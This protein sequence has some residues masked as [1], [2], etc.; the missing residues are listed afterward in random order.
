MP[1]YFRIS[2]TVL[3]KFRRYHA[4]QSSFDTEKALLDALAGVFIGTDKTAI[5]SAYHS[6]IEKAHF[7]PREWNGTEYAIFRHKG[8]TDGSHPDVGCIGLPMAS[9]QPV[10]EYSD[11][12]YRMF[13]EVP[14]S[15][16]YHTRIPGTGEIGFFVSG[17]ADGIEGITI[18]DAKFKFREA[19]DISEYM[20][21]MQWKITLDITEAPLFCFDLF[22]VQNYQGWPSPVNLAPDPSKSLH[23]CIMLNPDVQVIQ[24]PEIRCT[25]TQNLRGEIDELLFYFADWLH[26]RNLFHLLKPC[27]SDG[28][29]IR[30]QIP[31]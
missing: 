19:G 6:Q 30:P 9:L 15:K 7:T 4:N 11:A 13:R 8:I 23:P 26:F 12:H 29:V 10:A 25:P 2:I 31:G 24:Q 14:I 16:L 21:S 28:F 17:R 18:R 5:G 20:E 22:H 1:K 3:E 27:E